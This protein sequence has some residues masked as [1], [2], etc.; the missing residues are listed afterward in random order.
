ML[1]TPDVLADAILICRQ[2][3]GLPL[4]IELAIGWADTLSLQE[5]TQE[6]TRSFDFLETRRRDSSE[7]H[8]SIRAV[9]DPSLQTLSDADRAVLEG[10]CL[11]RSSFTREA[12]EAVT[13]ATSHS[14]GRLVSKSLVRHRPSGRYDIHELVR[15]YGEARLNGMSG[16]RE[17]AQECYCAYYA[18]FLEAQWREMKSA[19]RNTPFERIDSELANS[20]IAFQSMSENGRTEQIWQSMDALWNYLT[21]RYKL[22]EGA[23]LFGKSVE[24]LRASQHKALIGSLLI[25]Q[26]CFL[27]GLGSLDEAKR[28]AKEGLTLL[29]CHQDEVMADTF[30][31]AYLCLVLVHWFA[32][33]PQQLQ[34]AA[35]RGLEYS[36][37]NDHPFGIR[38]T[39]C[40]AANAELKL[41]NY[42]Q[43]REMGHRCYDL[44]VDQGDLWIQGLTAII[45]LAEVAY[46][47]GKYSE[48][49]RWC[50][51]TQRCLEDLSQPYS[52]ALT[53][54][55]LTTCS[56]AL[57]D[58]T[59]A[60]N[61]LNTCMQLL[62]ESGLA[63]QIP[64]ILLDMARLLAE[65]HMMEQAV[66]IL[67]LV[68]RHS[69]CRKTTHDEA[70]RLLDQLESAVPAD[71]FAVAWEYGHAQQS[72]H[73]LETLAFVYRDG[74]MQPSHASD[75]SIREQEV[76][77]LI[78]DGLSNAEIA[79]RLCLS[80]ST[81]KVHTRHI[82]G[83]LGVNSRI[84]AAFRAQEL[85]FL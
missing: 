19:M 54:H 53:S 38:S 84:Q 14:L 74:T 48:A 6:I 24:A 77:R 85:G 51:T 11:F 34:E 8:H 42:I 59:E 81:V 50:Q 29:E 45:V 20:M 76:L 79:Q 66:M 43:A 72:A 22:T 47:Q 52:L 40:F 58:F 64:P 39:M 31:V 23:L 78:V 1:I 32:D 55:R 12:A 28:L 36:I 46:A 70:T 17:V 63:W 56:V 49:R 73:V 62:D 10:L 44:A 69:A 7:R 60:Q 18:N 25:R 13:G 16:R 26:A 30:V 71:H 61:Y 27:A 3:Q 65:Q 21:I 35:C 15:Q 82:Y 2:V 80:I 67:S 83:K 4:A 57:Q 37:K 75:L 41:G 9:L 5:I 68:L 33:E